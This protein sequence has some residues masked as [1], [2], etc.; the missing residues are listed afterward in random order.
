M[1]TIRQLSDEYEI[2]KL[3][4]RDIQD[5]QKICVSNPQFYLYSDADST[6]E[7][8]AA[9]LHT[10]PP[11]KELKDKYYIG[12]FRDGR[13]HAVMDLIDGYPDPETAFIGFFMMNAEYSGK[14]E[15][16]R[17]VQK[18]CTSLRRDGFQRARLCI[19][20]GNPQSSHF[21]RKNGFV[22][23]KE[24]DRS[25]HIVII[26]DKTLQGEYAWQKQ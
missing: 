3:D 15:G 7:C 24:A 1:I 2:R 18:V 20:K 5:V 6:A 23:V 14:G 19:D 10:L 9:D 4:E 16:S 26:A 21:W 22:P 8:I 13:L 17:I 25:G 12:F 11:G